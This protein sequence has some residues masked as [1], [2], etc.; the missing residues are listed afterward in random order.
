MSNIHTYNLSFQNVQA[1]VVAKFD[2]EGKTKD[3]L[4]FKKGEVMTVWR[5]LDKNWYEGTTGGGG[6][7]GGATGGKKG[8]STLFSLN[9]NS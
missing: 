7:G 9:L 3:E 1:Q 2:F 5:Q 8:I 4:S 6:G